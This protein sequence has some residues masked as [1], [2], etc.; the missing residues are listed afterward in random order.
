M[1]MYPNVHK[2]IKYININNYLKILEIYVYI[3]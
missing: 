1:A 2:N 3:I